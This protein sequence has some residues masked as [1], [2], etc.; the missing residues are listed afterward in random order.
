MTYD[1]AMLRYGIDRPDTRFGLEIAR[2]RRRACAA[3]SS[4]S[5]SRVLAGGGVVRAI[6]A[7]ARELSR[8]ELDELNEVVPA[9]RREGRRPGRSSRTT[10]AGARRSRSSSR[11]E[12]IAAVN[13]ELEASEGDLL[14][15]VADRRRRRR[16]RARR[17]APGARPS[18]SA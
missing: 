12:Q 1:E 15:F 7:G 2:R 14:L 11:R 16:G 10:A 5:S 4:R 3:R 13:A 18:A 17:A 6:N 8:S 9:L